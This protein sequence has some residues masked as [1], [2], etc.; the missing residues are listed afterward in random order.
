MRFS[1]DSVDFL[2][3]AEAIAEPSLDKDK[4]SIC[5]LIIS[6]SIASKAV[7][8]E[9]ISIFNF[10]ADSS[11]KSM[12]LSGR[13]LSAMYLSDKLAASTNAASEIE[14]PW[15]NSY[16]SR[17]PL[18]IETV[19][20]TDGS[21]TKTCWKRLSNAG[22]FS[23]CCRNSSKVVAPTHRSSPRPNIGFN[24]FPA[25]IPPPPPFP[26]APT[27]VWI[28]SINKMILPIESTTSFIT[29]FKRSSNSPRNLAPAMSK[30]ISKDMIETSCN[31]VGTSPLMMRCANPSAM[32]VFPTPGSPI[33]TG[34]F[35]DL[36]D[37]I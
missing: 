21:S 19:S 18:K 26:P 7:G 33:N 9:V 23:I 5:N 8:F 29:A 32:A 11:T 17:K 27:T 16:L 1:L 13:Y 14:T 15:C 2:S 12:A 35:F 10:A 6:R 31:E 3:A 24:K 34:L 37:K 22:S 4:I 30:P 28:S 20:S 36:R 25:S